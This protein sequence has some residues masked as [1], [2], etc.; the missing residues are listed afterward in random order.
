MLDVSHPSDELTLL[1]SEVPATEFSAD[2]G[3]TL[4]ARFFPSSFDL[5]SNV[6]SLPTFGQ[7]N[8]D[9]NW[10]TWTNSL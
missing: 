1:I 2:I 7:P 9:G 4:T 10:L 5:T 3:R 8:D 6:A